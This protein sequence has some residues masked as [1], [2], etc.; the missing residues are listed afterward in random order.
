MMMMCV[1]KTGEG[2]EGASTFQN[3][4]I[5]IR[6]KIQR[7]KHMRGGLQGQNQCEISSLHRS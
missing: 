2:V 5:N 7:A 6:N 4:R 1:A 3:V